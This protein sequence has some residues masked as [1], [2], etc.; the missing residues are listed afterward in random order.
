MKIKITTNIEG[1]S[2]LTFIV[3][4]GYITQYILKSWISPLQLRYQALSLIMSMRVYIDTM[5]Y[6]AITLFTFH[7]TAT[8]WSQYLNVI[9][10]Y[11]YTCNWKKDKNTEE[12]LMQNVQ[13]YLQTIIL[14]YKQWTYDRDRFQD[15]LTE[16]T[17]VN[18]S[19]VASINKIDKHIKYTKTCT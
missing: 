15:H 8:H 6:T 10:I 16:I 9:P 12:I 4:F 2:F 3:M 5:Y 13:K 17:K 7:K 1:H 14:K 11:Q 19:C 18:I